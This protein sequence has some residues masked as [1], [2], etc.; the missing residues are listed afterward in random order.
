MA[1]PSWP[2]CESPFPAGWLW[3]ETRSSDVSLIPHQHRPGTSVCSFPSFRRS[4]GGGRQAS[5]NMK[6]KGSTGRVILANLNNSSWLWKQS[7]HPKLLFFFFPFPLYFFPNRNNLFPLLGRFLGQGRA[8][9]IA[10]HAP[11]PGAPQVTLE[12]ASGTQLRWIAKSKYANRAWIITYI[13]MQTFFLHYCLCPASCPT[14]LSASALSIAVELK[15]PGM[16][17]EAGREF[18]LQDGFSRHFLSHSLQDSCYSSGFHCCNLD[19]S[20]SE[21]R[22]DKCLV[23]PLQSTLVLF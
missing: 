4:Q 8:L 22:G 5:R 14:A 13:I 19:V 11:L 12:S 17:P 16:A 3:R 20:T 21:R 10:S 6:G 23:Q 9:P 1:R 15:H 7:S 18:N 2:S